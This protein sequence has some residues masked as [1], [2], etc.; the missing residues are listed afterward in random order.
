MYLIC[1]SWLSE[2]SSTRAMPHLRLGFLV[3]LV[4]PT[5]GYKL[6]AASTKAPLKQRGQI[7]PQVAE[8]EMVDSTMAQLQ[9]HDQR[10]QYRSNV[11]ILT[12]VQQLA[13][14]VDHRQKHQG[15]FQQHQIRGGKMEQEMRKAEERI[16][17]TRSG[18]QTSGQKVHRTSS[19][20]S[21]TRLDKEATKAIEEVAGPCEDNVVNEQCVEDVTN[22]WNKCQALVQDL[23]AIPEDSPL[24]TH[25][26][27]ATINK[28]LQQDC[29]TEAATKLSN[30]LHAADIASLVPIV[31]GL[32]NA[33]ESLKK[34]LESKEPIYDDVDMQRQVSKFFMDLQ[35]DYKQ[36]VDSPEERKTVWFVEKVNEVRR[37]LLDLFPKVQAVENAD[38][39][40][41]K[42]SDMLSTMQLI[43]GR[44]DELLNYEGVLESPQQQV[45]SPQQKDE[46]EK[47]CDGHICN[48]SQ[49]CSSDADCC[50][51]YSCGSYHSYLEARFCERP[52]DPMA[53]WHWD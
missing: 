19:R 48:G 29:G 51:G 5:L 39:D 40:M 25:A 18:S 33:T 2:M 36:L 28:P 22:L 44:M 30:A 53:N 3:V 49:W 52:R 20:D 38:M 8:G 9:E 4:A 26:W 15:D 43:K 31:A 11:G 23:K 12:K 17:G 45:E 16:L 14:H 10:F 7:A 1:V 27:I 47:C 50:G 37:D 34:L 32:E 13:Q 42:V 21:F 35:A 41:K 24:R 46:S 6:N